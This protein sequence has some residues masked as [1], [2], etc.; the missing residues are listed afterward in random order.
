[1]QSLARWECSQDSALTLPSGGSSF[2]VAN[3]FGDLLAF[4][5]RL[6]QVGLGASLGRCIAVGLPWLRPEIVPLLR[7]LGW[8]GPDHRGELFWRCVNAQVPTAIA[9]RTRLGRARCLRGPLPVRTASVGWFHASCLAFCSSGY[10]RRLPTSPS[11][12]AS[13]WQCVSRFCWF[14][15]F[16][17]SLRHCERRWPETLG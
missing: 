6:C 1:M 7:G 8:P 17:D 16:V 2:M 11:A 5:L 13:V 15:R 12:S 14:S 10:I 4:L 9:F 3:Q